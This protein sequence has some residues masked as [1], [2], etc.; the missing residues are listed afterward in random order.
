V[1]YINSFCFTDAHIKPLGPDSLPNIP[2]SSQTNRDNKNLLNS[3][4]YE[5]NDQNVVSELFA[6]LTIDEFK[7]DTPH[8][9]NKHDSNNGMNSKTN[10]S[11]EPSTEYIDM[12]TNQSLMRSFQSGF[13]NTDKNSDISKAYSIKNIEY[14]KKQSEFRKNKNVDTRLVNEKK[15]QSCSISVSMK[16]KMYIISLSKYNIDIIFF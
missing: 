13:N 1:K 3:R 12:C 10:E 16:Y 8:S 15:S 14:V 5:W 9:K 6:R 11:I 4:N 7:E 2:A